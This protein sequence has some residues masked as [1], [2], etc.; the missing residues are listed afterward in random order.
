[1]TISP[2]LISIHFMRILMAFVPDW[3]P[4]SVKRL[5]VR[6]APIA[7]LQKFRKV[8]EIMNHNAQNIYNTKKTALDKGDEAVVQQIGEGKDLLSIMSKPT[9]FN[10]EAAE[11]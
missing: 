5:V 3:I 8:V 2:T 10:Q 4:S 11:R 1:M 6:Y 9:G 7:S